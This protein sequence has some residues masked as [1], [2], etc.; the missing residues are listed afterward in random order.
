VEDAVKR[1]KWSLLNNWAHINGNHTESTDFLR[2]L[3][4]KALHASSENCNLVSNNDCKNMVD[5]FIFIT[6]ADTKVV[7]KL[8]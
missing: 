8:L 1:K 6:K 5:H 7:E 3:I 4:D 2:S